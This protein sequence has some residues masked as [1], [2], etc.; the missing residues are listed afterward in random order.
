MSMDVSS[1]SFLSDF[2]ERIEELN[3]KYKVKIFERAWKKY[4]DTGTASDIESYIINTWKSNLFTLQEPISD[5]QRLAIQLSMRQA[6]QGP[7][8]ERLGEYVY[9]HNMIDEIVKKTTQYDRDETLKYMRFQCKIR[10]FQCFDIEEKK[11]KI[12]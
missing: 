11:R 1:P 4:I 8:E 6:F 2:N 3:T 7:I 10:I 12:Q 5:I 9:I